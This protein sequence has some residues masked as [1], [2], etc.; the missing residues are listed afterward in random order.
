[1]LGRQ[2]IDTELGLIA[3]F[4]HQTKGLCGYMDNIMGNDLVSPHGLQIA[5]TTDFTESWRVD[6]S[7][8]NPGDGSWSWTYSNFHPDD[9]LD[10]SYTNPYHRAVYGTNQLPLKERT[11][12]EREC[13]A[14]ELEGKLLNDCILDRALT[15]D[16]TVLQQQ[17]FQQGKCPNGCS[18]RG[19]C[20][21]GTCICVD[22][23]L[24]EDCTEGG[25]D[26]CPQ[27]SQCTDG[28]CQCNFGHYG[29]NCTKG[30]LSFST[31]VVKDKPSHVI[32]AFSYLSSS[33]QLYQFNTWTM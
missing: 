5:N 7:V 23:W 11:E 8:S 13:L 6:Q 33:K 19:Q 10:F 21:N 15:G 25:C 17:A 31:S 27:N 20:K 1:M 12:A 26:N 22:S 18:N 9:P 30:S 3:S 24:G 2:Y 14:L 16:S 4:M 29:P 28:F 32:V